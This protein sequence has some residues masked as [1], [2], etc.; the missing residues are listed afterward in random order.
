MGGPGLDVEFSEEG[1]RLVARPKGRLE[2]AEADSF[3]SIV[4]ARLKPAFKLVLIDLKD[5]NFISFR[6]LRA[7][8]RLGKLLKAQDRSIAFAY[9]KGDVREELE[10]SGLEV[11]FPSP[12]AI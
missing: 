10:S 3:V 5:L 9:A 6:G 1:E 11:I 8:L 12:A 4:E 2:T 7:F